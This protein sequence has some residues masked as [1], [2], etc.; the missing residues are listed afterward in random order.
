MWRD[1][2]KSQFKLHRKQTDEAKIAL[3]LADARNLI[4]YLDGVKMHRIYSDA[5]FSVSTLSGF[6]KL[7][8]TAGVVGFA[9]PKVYD[10]EHPHEL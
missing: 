8:R 1:E 3:L 6:E 10:A 9:L 2:I 5:Y 4:T 7:K